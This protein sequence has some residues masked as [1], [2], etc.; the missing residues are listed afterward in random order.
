MTDAARFSIDPMASLLDGL[1]GE[2][3]HS[4]DNSLVARLKNL[5]VEYRRQHAACIREQ[6]CSVLG[7]GESD[8]LKNVGKCGCK[9]ADQC[10]FVLNFWEIIKQSGVL[11]QSEAT[12]E[13]AE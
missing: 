13:A 8:G 2:G 11:S 6:Q 3:Q 7:I 4:I 10:P 9:D 12:S 5:G 1:V